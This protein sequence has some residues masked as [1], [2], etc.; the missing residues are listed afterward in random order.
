MKLQ[1]NGNRFLRFALTDWLHLSC[2]TCLFAHDMTSW[3]PPPGECPTYPR[4]LLSSSDEDILS[5]R[6]MSRF[7]IIFK[8]LLANRIVCTKEADD[9][10]LADQW[11]I[12][13][14]D[15]NLH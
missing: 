14:L 4:L 1:T 5:F 8:K 2:D 9:Y 13:D 6:I 15:L 11:D 12:L 10:C 3:R 7:C